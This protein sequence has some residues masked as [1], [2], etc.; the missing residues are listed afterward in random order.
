MLKTLPLK[1]AKKI[2]VQ[3]KNETLFAILN[4]S[5]SVSVTRF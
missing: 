3:P 5:K 2:S 4:Y 1:K